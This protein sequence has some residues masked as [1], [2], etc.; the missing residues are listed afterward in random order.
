[1]PAAQPEPV[2]VTIATQPVGAE[3]YK[4]G[5]LLGNAPL[6]IDRPEGEQSVE[7]EVRMAG[8]AAKT[9]AIT[10]MT[11]E[12]LNITL[13]KVKRRATAKPH[14]KDTAPA[15]TEAKPAPVKTKRRVQSE[16]LDPWD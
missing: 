15:K 12:E 14:A 2:K 9:F 7:L 3:V 1:M 16:V 11:S 6:A 5:A 4:Q 13:A 10:R 8:Y